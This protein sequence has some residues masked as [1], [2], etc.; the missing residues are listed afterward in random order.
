M[1]IQSPDVRGSFNS[2]LKF[3]LTQQNLSFRQTKGHSKGALLT[4]HLKVSSGTRNGVDKSN[5]GYHF[6][7]ECT[8]SDKKIECAC[9]DEEGRN[10]WVRKIHEASQLSEEV[11]YV[12]TFKRTSSYTREHTQTLQHTTHLT[13]H[14]CVVFSSLTPSAPVPSPPDP[15]TF[16]S[17]TDVLSANPQVSNRTYRYFCTRLVPACIFMQLGKP[18]QR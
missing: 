5:D 11:V 7:V 14:F 10:M 18:M 3:E 13:P 16:K 12:C 1:S 2:S 6:T 9:A 8:L 4:K 17:T 15:Q